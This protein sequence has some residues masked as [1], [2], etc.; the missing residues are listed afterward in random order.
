[1]D[2]ITLSLVLKSLAVLAV[3]TGYGLLVWAGSIANR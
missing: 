1:M 3:C 2:D